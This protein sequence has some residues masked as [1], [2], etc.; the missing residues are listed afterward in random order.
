MF[1]LAKKVT[2]FALMM[3][4]V[5]IPFNAWSME[6]ASAKSPPPPKKINY[7][8]AFI[9]VAHRGASGHAPENTIAAFDKAVAMHATSFE[10]DVQRTKDGH[11]VIMHDTTV[12]R[13]TNG[14]GA[15]KDLTLK[16]IRKLDAGSWFG[17]SFAGEKV[18][19]LRETLKRYRTKP[20]RIVIEL[21]KP[22]L[23]PGIEKQVAHMLTKTGLTVI[24]SK[25]TV[26][27]FN[28]SSIKKYHHLQPRVKTGVIVSL[29]EY[30]KGVPEQKLTEWKAFANYINPNYKLVNKSL[31]KKIHDRK[32]K[33]LPYTILD[34]KTATAVRDMG[35][36][37]MIT[38][39]PELGK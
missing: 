24:P 33:I 10:F 32:M 23:Y 14:K 29:T 16:Q 30:S 3:T 28:A 25:V 36:D 7:H 39:Y 35:V 31:V 34:K 17:K 19:T 20:I 26:Q 12:D 1:G 5:G 21:K 27:S 11:L 9:N 4:L 38:N 6:K 15:V 13:T 18:P 2:V 22:E 37:G 8:G